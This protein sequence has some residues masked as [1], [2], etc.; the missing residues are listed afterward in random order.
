MEAA[1]QSRSMKQKEDDPMP[2]CHSASN[3][4]YLPVCCAVAAYL[5]FCLSAQGEDAPAK[6]TPK[7]LVVEVKVVEVSLT[8]LK[9][10]GFT[11][12]QLEADGSS[13]S[14]FMDKL[15]QSPNAD[16]LIK[17]LE[18]L[19]QNSLAR[20]LAEPTIATLDGRPASFVAGTTHLD[21]VPI[22]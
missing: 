11:W 7:K 9:N 13:K 1:N 5:A 18:P 19:R 6:L 22:V 3:R 8:N 10:L 4:N 17:F 12:T 14:D 16:N 15:L 2:N 21:I 20:V